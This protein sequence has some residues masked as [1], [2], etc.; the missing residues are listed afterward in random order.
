M[1]VTTFWVGQDG[2][3]Y[4]KNGSAAQN[5]G[6]ADGSGQ[7]NYVV[8][9]GQL[10]DKWGDN[11]P[12]A[13]ASQQIQDPATVKAPAA[14]K[15]PAA[16]GA[17]APV[18]NQAAASNTQATIDQIPAL[19]QAALASEATNY[20]NTTGG[21]QA[22]QDQ[23]QKT[24]DTSTT[25]NQNNYDSNYMDSIRAGIKGLGGLMQLLRG[26]GAAGGSAD[27][28]VRDTVGGVTANDI[29]TGADTQQAN[30]GSLDSSLSQFLTDLGVKRKAADDTHVN[31]DRAINRDSQTQ[32]QDLYGKM[33]GFYGDAG[34]TAASNDWMAR[35][36]AITPSIAANSVTQTSPYD[37]TPVAVQAPQLTAFAGPTQPSVTTAPSDGQ[38]GAGIFTMADRKK[39]NQTPTPSQV[40]V[41]VGV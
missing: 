20:S 22:Q 38:I 12:V 21:F 27:Q 16:A 40:P 13:I 19:L 31:N 9:N 37:T 39:Q 28:S 23:Q 41:A 11:G 30:Q 18:F 2:N 24:Y 15:A 32:L 3:I 4:V 8:Q 14:P 7:G 17:A 35:A 29:R 36:G 6:A 5:M 26:T 10:V 33:A 25:T 34:N 1:A